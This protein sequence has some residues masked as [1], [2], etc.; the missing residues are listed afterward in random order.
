MT[1]ISKGDTFA[2][3]QQLTASRLNQLVDS[4]TLVVGAITDQAAMTAKT[5]EA[6]DAIIVSDS[7]VLK[8]A[9]IEDVLNSNIPVVAASVTTSVIDAEI[10]KDV[11][12]TP[13]DGVVVTSKVFTS[14]NG[15]T[16]AIASVAHGLTTGQVVQVT[17]SITEYSGT[18]R[19]IVTSIDEFSYT[20]PVAVTAASG[21]CSYVKKASE[22]VNGQLSISGSQHIVGSSTVNGSSTVGGSLVVIGNSTINGTQEVKGQATFTLIPKVGEIPVNPRI[23]YFVQTRAQ[24]TLTSGWGGLQNPANLYGTKIPLL[25]ITLTPKKAGNKIILNWS[26][27]CECTYGA[28][29][30]LLVTRTPLSGAGANI[31]VALPDAVDASNNTWSGINLCYDGD[32]STTPQAR[33][34]SIVD[35]NTL[36]VECTYSVHFRGANNRTSIFY[37]NRSGSSAGA[38]DRET[39]LSLGHAQEIHI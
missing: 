20:I 24:A 14:A 18:F 5:L 4:A 37:L 3:S 15:T 28:E 19:I 38:L 34:V 27:F 32:D 26:I 29:T 7:G 11:I 8:K 17:A 12:I 16:V 31:P 33:T 13:F 9:T 2:D 21:T 1:Q 30:M 23:D 6:T 39:G 10:N 35:L 22:V 36:D 25:D